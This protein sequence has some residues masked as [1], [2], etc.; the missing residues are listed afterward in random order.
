MKW[1][2]FLPLMIGT[3][4]S[5]LLGFTV[6]KYFFFIFTWIGA[7]ITF[8]DLISRGAKDQQLGRK[9]AILLILPL[10]LVFFGILQREN[11]QMEETI[12]YLAYFFAGGIFTRVLIHF[13]IAKV[14]GPFI[15]GR[16]FCG[17]ACWTAAVLEW[18]PI[19]ENRPIPK[20]LTYIRI[21]VLVLTILIPFFMIQSGYDYF[22]KHIAGDM[23]GLIQTAKLD[24]FYWFLA[25]NVLYYVSGIILAF[26]FR[27]KRAF[28]KIACPVSLVMKAQTAIALLKVSPSGKKCIECGKCNTECP[29][30]VH[31]MSYISKGKKVSSTECINCGTCS[32][33]CPANAIS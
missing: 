5:L 18:L 24:Q 17:W 3:A 28:C 9:L 13:A 4:L 11:M 1:T 19:K 26:V 29:M 20:G 23:G 14:V 16:G 22:N 25:G 21:P 2:D 15:W 27:K 12:F 31:V 8:G 30:D 32:Q 6:W 10:F 33:V 7:C